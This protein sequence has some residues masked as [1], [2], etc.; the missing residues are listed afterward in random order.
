[1][2]PKPAEKLSTVSLRAIADKSNDSTTGVTNAIAVKTVQMIGPVTKASS[3]HTGSEKLFVGLGQSNAD[4]VSVVEVGLPVSVVEY[5][6]KKTGLEVTML[7]QVLKISERT[8]ARRRVEGQ[9]S[10][11][12][13]D[14]VLRLHRLLKRTESVIGEGAKDWLHRPNR[15]LNGR[16]PFEL[17]ETETGAAAVLDVL[18]RIEHGVFS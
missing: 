2:A 8:L 17:S 9:L 4:D 18:G 13:S 12:E 6:A 11:L 14:R 10:T 1:M 16:V 7:A 5:T 15:A 3:L